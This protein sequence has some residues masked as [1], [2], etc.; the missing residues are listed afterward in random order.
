[1]IYIHLEAAIFAITTDEFH[2]LPKTQISMR[3]Y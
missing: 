1:M 3:I 2:V